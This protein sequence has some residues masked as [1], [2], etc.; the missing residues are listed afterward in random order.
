[1]NSSVL[2]YYYTSRFFFDSMIWKTCNPLIIELKKIYR[3]E[4]EFF[5]AILNNIRNGIYDAEDIESLN[6][7]YQQGVD[8]SEIITLTTHNHKA[9]KINQEA[10]HKLK[11]QPYHLKG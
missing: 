9:N 2:R 6:Q 1:M 11:T 4:D 7:R 10:L 5:I 8:T 3:Q